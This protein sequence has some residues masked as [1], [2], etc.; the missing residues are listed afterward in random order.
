M[1]GRAINAVVK[2][3]SRYPIGRPSRNTRV[4]EL[5]QVFLRTALILELSTL[6]LSTENHRGLIM[7]VTKK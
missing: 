6:V 4:T 2:K 5:L 3:P 1:A 7:T